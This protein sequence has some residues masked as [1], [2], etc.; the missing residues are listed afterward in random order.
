MLGVVPPN[1]KD[2][3]SAERWKDYIE[4]LFYLYQETITNLEKGDETLELDQVEMVRGEL[5]F[6]LKTT[7][8]ENVFEKDGFDTVA[9]I[10]HMN[11]VLDRLAKGGI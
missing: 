2:V 5:M 9:E 6:F 8:K 7:Q 3:L 1:T 11:C 10:T 4:T